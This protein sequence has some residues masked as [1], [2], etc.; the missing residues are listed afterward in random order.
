MAEEHFLGAQAGLNR[1]AELA[2][3][4]ISAT[5]PTSGRLVLAAVVLAENLAFALSFRVGFAGSRNSLS[6][7]RSDVSD[8]LGPNH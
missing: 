2:R 5:W 3:E 8:Q 1:W 7:P 6:K 4:S